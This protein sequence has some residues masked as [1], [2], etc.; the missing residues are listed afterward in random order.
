M[1]S[2]LGRGPRLGRRRGSVWWLVALLWCLPAWGDDVREAIEICRDIGER[3]EDVNMPA[4]EVAGWIRRDARIYTADVAE[5]L[6]V[7]EAPRRV[8]NEV[9]RKVWSD[10]IEKNELAATTWYQDDL[11]WS[12]EQHVGFV[13]A[14]AL[15]SEAGTVPGFL[16]LP[17]RVEPPGWLD[18]SK[19]LT[20]LAR[21]VP[22]SGLMGPDDWLGDPPRA[23][24]LELLEQE[25]PNRTSPQ[26]RGLRGTTPAVLWFDM[27]AVPEGVQVMW[28]LRKVPQGRDDDPL[29]LATGSVTL[30]AVS[31]EMVE[32]CADP[33]LGVTYFWSEVRDASEGR[34]ERLIQ[35]R[36]KDPL[37]V[38]RRV[39]VVLGV[40]VGGGIDLEGPRGNVLS[41][42]EPFTSQGVRWTD[43][44]EATAL[45]DQT[46]YVRT[47]VEL[48]FQI[49]GLRLGSYFALRPVVGEA[50]ESVSAGPA[51]NTV[52]RQTTW[53][54]DG[55]GS[56]LF[57][58]RNPKVGGWFGVFAE[59]QSRR[60]SSTLGTQEVGL[61]A[62]RT[63]LGPQLT[64][65]GDAGRW[66]GLGLDLRAGLLQLSALGD[67]H[68]VTGFMVQVDGGVR[69][70]F[71]MR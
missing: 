51:G 47:G 37:D 17:T 23:P 60:A 7:D 14:Q 61:R 10:W 43:V 64:L 29:A 45:W 25:V 31:G 9:R 5:C 18:A 55:G 66:V 53:A 15:R 42:T 56:L 30:K 39:G 28:A 59:G 3:I 34:A 13:V 49:P 63:V 54:L 20:L 4:E 36:G 70:V 48:A 69:L 35:R 32:R 50:L 12:A 71:R 21:E 65:E 24:L 8:Q 19:V 11:S 26:V 46:S 68:G 22:G 38:V 40:I 58:A 33:P 41:A 27:K 67:P 2:L 6:C 62:P 16:I 57:G 1:T 52:R 44:A